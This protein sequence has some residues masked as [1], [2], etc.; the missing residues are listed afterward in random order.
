VATLGIDAE[1]SSFVDRMLMPLRGTPAY[2]YGALRMLARY[3]AP[4]V[5]IEGDFGVIEKRI[6]L[7][8][9]AN[10]S[11]YGGAI[12][13]APDA[14]PTDGLLDL[15]VINEVGLLRALAMIPIVMAG[16]HARQ[17]EVSFVRTRQATIETDAPAEIWADGERIARTPAVIEVVPDALEV[18]VPARKHVPSHGR[19]SKAG[20]GGTTEAKAAAA[21]DSAQVRG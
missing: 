8:S 5:R 19:E 13:I 20:H 7:A 16:R 17:P 11:S 15:C 10:T 14:T 9:S 2:I 12:P 3:R 4:L 6:F 18:I 21:T 1:V